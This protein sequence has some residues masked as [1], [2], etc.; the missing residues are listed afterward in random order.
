ME[1]YDVRELR[2]PFTIPDLH[3]LHSTLELVTYDGF[4]V[5]DCLKKLPLDDGQTAEQVRM[6]FL[7]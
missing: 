5:F 4:D 1:F 3:K 7:P 6:F 2:P